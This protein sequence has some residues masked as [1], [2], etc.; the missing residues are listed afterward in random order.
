MKYKIVVGWERNVGKYNA[1]AVSRRLQFIHTTMIWRRCEVSL[2][3]LFL[4]S[5]C[6]QGK[7]YIAYHTD[8]RG[9]Y[10]QTWRLGVGIIPRGRRR[11]SSNQT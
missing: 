5:A 6:T 2:K 7:Q 9:I 1:L 4:A 8:S 11:A 3:Q 10:T